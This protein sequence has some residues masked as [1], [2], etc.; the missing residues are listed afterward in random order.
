MK[1]SGGVKVIKPT[2]ELIV[3]LF[4]M[5]IGFIRLGEVFLVVVPLLGI[6]LVGVLLFFP[7]I[8]V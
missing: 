6:S 2:K 1:S 8:G 7:D 4:H 3:V 5:R